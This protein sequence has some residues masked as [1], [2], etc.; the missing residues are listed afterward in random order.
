MIEVHAR[1]LSTVP[2]ALVALLLMDA[3]QLTNSAALRHVL[4]SFTSKLIE[5]EQA[6]SMDLKMHSTHLL[7]ELLERQSTLGE[8]DIT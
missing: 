2:Y 5:L 7:P 3:T 6:V 1:A 8:I 4:S